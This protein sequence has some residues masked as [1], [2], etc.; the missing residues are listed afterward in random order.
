MKDKMLEFMSGRQLCVIST[1]GAD[2]KP[3]SA[4]VAYIHNDFELFIGTSNTSRK[5]QNLLINPSVAVVIADLEAGVQYE[6]QATVIENE[7]LADDSLIKYLPG[8][9]KYRNDPTQVYIHVKPTWIRFTEHGET[10]KVE[11]FTEF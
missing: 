3:E 11:E 4:M 1:V 5:F 8:Y 2:T 9:E 7:A 10:D 6:G